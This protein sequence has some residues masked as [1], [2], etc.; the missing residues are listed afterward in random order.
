[1]PNTS[2]LNRRSV[3]TGRTRTGAA[4]LA[5]GGV[6]LAGGL[7]L[8]GCSGGSASSSGSSATSGPGARSVPGAAFAAPVPSA[9]A[10]GPAGQPASGRTTARLAPASDIIYTAQLTVR[11]ANVGTAAARATQTAEDVGG[12]VSNENSSANPDRP[13]EATATVQLKIPVTSYPATLGQLASGLG[14]QLSLQEQAQDVTEQ[15]ADVNSQVTSFQA[16]IAQ[17]RALLSHA[18]S[19]GDLLSVQNQINDEESALEALQAQQRAL[20][21]ETT[22]ATVTLTI[23]GPEAKPAAHH[24]KAPPSLAGGLGAGWHALRVTVSWI[25]A[26]IGAVAPFAAVAALGGFVVYRGRRWLIRRRPAA[27]PASP[28]N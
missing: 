17:L 26:F 15:V 18:G 16:A 7:F 8:A 13:S 9:A 23:L 21:H 4:A 24:P 2:S 19:I 1:M 27:R 5:I 28:E 14:T 10:S 6:M 25:L 12:Y 11:V 20:S 22:Y 3:R